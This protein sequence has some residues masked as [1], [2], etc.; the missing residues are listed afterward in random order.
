MSALATVAEGPAVRQISMPQRLALRLAHTGALIR[1]A[2]G[3]WF[4][5]P[6]PNQPVTNQTV[7]ALAARGL[8][9]VASY[10][11]LYEERACAV[12]TPEGRAANCGVRLQAAAPPPVTAEAVLRD[13]EQALAE[14][15]AQE[16]ALRAEI[17]ADS[18]AIRAARRSIAEA[19]A[20][21]ARAERTL[22]RR[23]EARESLGRRRVELAALV[24]HAADRL[25]GVIAETG[26]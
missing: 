5:R 25:G 22:Q 17:L 7:Q 15:D 18:E 4:A 24:A 10:A 13:V 19:E 9:R 20:R 12:L 16:A 26:R 23:E 11:G 3:N 8:L 2:G 21:V 1:A 6:F 14:L